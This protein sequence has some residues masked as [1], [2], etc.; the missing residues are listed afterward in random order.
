MKTSIF[1]EFCFNTWDGDKVHDSYFCADK[2]V[3]NDKA[4][5][6]K[7]IAKEKGR[8]VTVEL[9]RKVYHEGVGVIAAIHGFVLVLSW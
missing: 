2:W 3:A 8:N 7:L 1:Y 5:E 9:V 6:V 4:E